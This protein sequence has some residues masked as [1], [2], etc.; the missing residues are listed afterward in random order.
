[1]DPKRRQQQEL[2]NKLDQLNASLQDARTQIDR[3]QGEIASLEWERPD[4]YIYWKGKFLKLMEYLWK[5]LLELWDW[6]KVKFWRW[7]TGRQTHLTYPEGRH[8]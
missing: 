1:M 4:Q 5:K 8:I 3:L 7:W 2:Q 6:V